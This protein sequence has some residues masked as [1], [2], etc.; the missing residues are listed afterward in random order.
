MAQLHLRSSDQQVAFLFHIYT[1]RLMSREEI[2]DCLHVGK[3][4]FSLCGSAFGLILNPPLSATIGPPPN[5]SPPKVITVSVNTIVDRAEQLDCHKPRKKKQTHDRQVL[6]SSIGALIQHDRS[7]HRWSSFPREKWTLI[8]SIDDY[9]RMLLFADFF[10][11]ETSWAHIQATQALAETFGLPL[12]YYVHSLRV[13]RSVQG[14][15]S[16]WRKHVLQTDDVDTQWSKMMDLLGI[17][18]IYALSPLANGKQA[19]SRRALGAQFGGEPHAAPRLVA[20]RSS[21]PR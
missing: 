21:P 20:G 2:E 15:D 8:T 17:D 12:R 7:A 11:A 16:F 9:S 13:F 18:V 1:S 4:R 5:A 6:T 19:G 14:R 10:P 3:T